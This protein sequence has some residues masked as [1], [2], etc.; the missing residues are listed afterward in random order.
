M[1]GSVQKETLFPIYKADIEFYTIGG[2]A[3]A[4]EVE[5]GKR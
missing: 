1:S 5:R 3:K 2:R 4:G